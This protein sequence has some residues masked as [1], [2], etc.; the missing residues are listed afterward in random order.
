MRRVL[1]VLKVLRVLRVLRVLTVRYVMGF[2]ST[3]ASSE[4]GGKPRM[5]PV[6]S[7]NSETLLVF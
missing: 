6:N 2:S 7:K 3:A 4:D 1:R 5:Q